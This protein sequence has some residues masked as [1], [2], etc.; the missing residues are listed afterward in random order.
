MS[1]NGV[2]DTETYIPLVTVVIP[3][4]NHEKWVNDAIDSVLWQDYPNKRIV[5][6]DDGSTDDSTKRVYDRMY[7]PKGPEKQTEPFMF[8]GK[9][10]HADTEIMVCKFQEAHGPSFARNWGVKVSWDGTDVFFFLDSDDRYEPGKITKSVNKWLEMPDFIGAVYTDYDTV[11]DDGIRLRQF[12]EPVSR[13]R[14]VHDRECLPNCD[15]L[16]SKLALSKCGLFDEQMRTCED[17]DLWMRISERFTIVHI[18]ESLLTL[19]VGSHSSTA[20]VPSEIWQQNFQR[21]FQKAHARQL[22]GKK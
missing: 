2:N 12:Q 8:A 14:L 3:C 13:I 18:P 21:V 19:R 6:V 9:A 20:T 17:F 11:N 1:S 15:S 4:H 5:V 22:R 10:Q 7:R 16:V